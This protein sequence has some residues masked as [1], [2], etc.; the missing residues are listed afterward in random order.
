MAISRKLNSHVPLSILEIKGIELDV[1]KGL[2]DGLEVV[3]RLTEG[4]VEGLLVCS[5]FRYLDDPRASRLTFFFLD[6][7]AL[8]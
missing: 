3:G 1:M 2:V 8:V 6:R 5:L 7:L 4:G